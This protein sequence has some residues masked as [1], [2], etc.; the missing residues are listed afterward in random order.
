M[1]G[2]GR[3]V[4]PVLRPGARGQMQRDEQCEEAM[5]VGLLGDGGC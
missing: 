3:T 5:C 2:Q 1:R 4:L